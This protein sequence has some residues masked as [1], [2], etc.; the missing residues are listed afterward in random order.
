[1]VAKTLFHIFC[2]GFECRQKNENV[3]FAVAK[4][5]R[6]NVRWQKNTTSLRW[7]SVRAAIL[8]LL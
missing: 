1:M 6:Q 3:F 5:E 2:G 7:L 8:S 4:I